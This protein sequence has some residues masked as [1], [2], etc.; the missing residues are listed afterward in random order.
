MKNF[1]LIQQG[2]PLQLLLAVASCHFTAHLRK[3]RPFYNPAL[4]NGKPT[5]SSLDSPTS[6]IPRLNQSIAITLNSMSHCPSPEHRNNP[7]HTGENGETP[8][9]AAFPPTG[10]GFYG[11]GLAS[12]FPFPSVK[13]HRLG[14][15]H[16]QWCPVNSHFPSQRHRL[17]AQS[18]T[19]GFRTRQKQ[20]VSP[21]QAEDTSE[22]PVE[23]ATPRRTNCAQ[24]HIPKAT[25]P[26]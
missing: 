11:S 16:T 15:Q 1:P 18:F 25:K 9:S 24:Y 7:L 8:T 4:G 23:T 5:D 3:L 17:I 13:A 19:R 12:G 21:I 6:A 14:K 2:F 10:H 20:S 22:P 26:K